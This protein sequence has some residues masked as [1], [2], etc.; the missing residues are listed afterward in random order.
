MA[1]TSELLG[2]LGGA[3][4]EV[5]PV[6]VTVKS[7][8]ILYVG[9]VPAGETWKVFVVGNVEARHTSRHNL[10]EIRVGDT[11]STFDGEGGVMAEVSAEFQVTMRRNFSL[12][13][14]SFVGNV[15]IV[16]E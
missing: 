9:D 6:S 8:S 1:I 16:R 10:P 2:K 7:T 11:G 14:D 5:I 13:E 12:G 4:V 3:D 15:Y